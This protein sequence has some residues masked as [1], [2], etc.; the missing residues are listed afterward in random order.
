MKDPHPA[1]AAAV[2]FNPVVDA[3]KADDW[4]HWGAF[5]GFYAFD[6]I[7]GMETRTDAPTNYPYEQNEIYSWM[8]PQGALGNSLGPRLD[9]R[10]D[11]RTLTDGAAF[12]LPYYLG[13]Y[14]GLIIE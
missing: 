13:L 7:Y 10:H 6:F 3:W 9:E 2:P 12:L 14:H 1:L 11:G 8:L 4:F 5:R